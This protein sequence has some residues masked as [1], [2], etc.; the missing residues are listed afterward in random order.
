VLGH[1][2]LGAGLLVLSA[3]GVIVPWRAVQRGE[4]FV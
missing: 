4:A 1:A 2:G 3:I